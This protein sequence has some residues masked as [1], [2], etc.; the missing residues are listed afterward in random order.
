MKAL[1]FLTKKGNK[2]TDSLQVAQKFERRHDHV[3][4]DIVSI[5]ADYGNLPKLGE[6]DNPPANQLFATSTY[7]DARGRRQTYYVISELG[8]KLLAMRMTG[9]KAFRFQAQFLLAFEQL[10][11][12]VK[13]L[14]AQLTAQQSAQEVAR[15]AVYTNVDKQI[16]CVKG[17]AGA[18]IGKSKEGFGIINHHRSVMKLL[19]GER[20]SLYVSHAVE[21]GL[22]VKGKSGRAVLRMREPHKAATAAVLDDAVRAGKT[23]AE[24]S[25][26]GLAT[27]LP[28][29]FQTIL[30]LGLQPADL[31]AD[32]QR[33]A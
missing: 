22:R 27:T 30:Q 14:K 26:A 11:L 3:L 1:V 7:V 18:L 24:I 33:A 28:A 23:M 2:A 6:I 13:E 8:F 4:R 12:E 15:L 19:T 31:Q 25:A 9:P 20:P 5:L 16:E 29:A 17:V 32:H 10:Q 21:D